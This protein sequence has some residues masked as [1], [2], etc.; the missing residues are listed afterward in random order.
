MVIDNVEAMPISLTCEERDVLETDSTF[1]GTELARM[2]PCRCKWRQLHVLILADVGKYLC[3]DPK[4]S[5]DGRAPMQQPC[6]RRSIL[7]QDDRYLRSAVHL[8]L[9]LHCV[10]YVGC[11]SLCV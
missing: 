3:K 4:R 7:E 5:G 8:Q 6:R 9:S 1:N 10:M 2:C 11:R